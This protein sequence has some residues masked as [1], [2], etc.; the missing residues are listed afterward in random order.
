M[1]KL[2]FT[3]GS[4]SA[5]EAYG[6]FIQDTEKASCSSRFYGNKLTKE[7]L[8]ADHESECLKRLLIPSPT[9]RL[10]TLSTVSAARVRRLIRLFTAS[11]RLGSRIYCKSSGERNTI[12]SP[13]SRTKMYC[14]EGR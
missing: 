11:V 4:F 14:P 2:N 6:S 12:P 7:T 13:L 1:S 3:T 9:P 10:T 8:E 5:I